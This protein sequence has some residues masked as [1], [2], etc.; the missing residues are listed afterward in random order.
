M[1]RRLK[2]IGYLLLLFAGASLLQ[3]TENVAGA[4]SETTNGVVGCVFNRDAT[5][6][7]EVIVKLFPD[8]YNPIADETGTIHTDTTDASGRYRFSN[9][10]P[11]LYTVL[12]RGNGSS[13]SLLIND[14]AVAK[15]SVTNAPT[16]TLD[17]SGCIAID[18]TAEAAG[19]GGYLYLPGT[20]IYSTFSGGR[21]VLLSDIPSGTFTEVLQVN[22]DGETR[23]MVRDTVTVT[24]GDTTVIEHPSWRFSRE[25]GL[26]TS[27]TGAG[28]ADDVCDFPV[29][30]RLTDDNFDFAQAAPDGADLLF[31]GSGGILLPYEIE[32]W[33]VTGKQ[34]ELWIRVDTI[35]GNDSDQSI[36]MYWGNTEAI[37]RSDGEMVFDT[38]DGFLGVWHFGDAGTDSARDATVNGYHGV[39]SDTA[40]PYQA[41][42]I[43]GDSR[44]FNGTS[45]YITMPN[46][47]S[48]RLNLPQNGQYTISAWVFID[49][50]DTRSHVIASKGNSQY[51]LW[52]TSIHLDA[53]LWEFA[54]YRSESGWDLSVQPLSTGA[55]V[56]LTGVRNGTTQ[57]LYVNGV[58]GDTLID[59]PFSSARDSTFDLMIGR[60]AQVMASPDNNEGYCYFDG[61]IDEVRISGRARNA[62]WIRLCYM[63][64]QADNKLVVFR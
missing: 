10:A 40:Y 12:A 24:S 29:L 49:S 35:R 18:L 37:N 63:N 20:D 38:A 47:A 52:Y 22:A 3:C 21:M 53:T 46:T 54:D 19:T 9:I 45:S 26:N 60:F 56:L 64:Q 13:T 23:N 41:E 42:G 43:V 39:S 17:T 55:W 7:S 27:M 28:V 62:A 59:F 51:F 25:I 4:G 2:N 6:S 48:S 36:I 57:Y 61:G 14:I 1:I 34:A 50:T 11:G 8:A 31:S 44:I 58:S 16:G 30:V 5:A 33:D 32:R 15:D